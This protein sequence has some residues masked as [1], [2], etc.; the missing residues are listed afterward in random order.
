VSKGVAFNEDYLLRAFLQYN[1]RFK[2]AFMNTF[3]QCFYEDRF[4]ADFPL[5]LEER[6]GSIWLRKQN[7]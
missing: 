2:I 3:M 6:S 1:D 5:C 7:D 4:A